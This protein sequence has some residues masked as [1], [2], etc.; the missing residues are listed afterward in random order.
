MILSLKSVNCSANGFI[1]AYV[2]YLFSKGTLLL[3]SVNCSAR[4]SLSLTSVTCSARG[5]LSLMSVNCSARGSLSLTSVNWSVR[6]CNDLFEND[7]LD[8][9]VSSTLLASSSYFFVSSSIFSDCSLFFEL[10]LTMKLA[11]QSIYLKF[12]H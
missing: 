4:G 3:R 10:R 1:I 11:F 6:V 7:K 5:S 2:C 9:S 12:G 8:D